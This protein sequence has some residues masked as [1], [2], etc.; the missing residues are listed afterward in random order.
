VTQNDDTPISISKAPT[1]STEQR[2]RHQQW[3][4][5][6][7][8]KHAD[9]TKRRSATLAARRTLPALES[10]AEL[11]EGVAYS[12]RAGI[13]EGYLE[14]NDEL[15]R[16]LNALLALLKAANLDA[17]IDDLMNDPA[18]EI[19]RDVQMTEQILAAASALQTYVD[20]KADPPDPTLAAEMALPRPE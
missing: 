8:V 9:E 3:A 7:E 17:G 16:L 19:V 10:A 11:G 4:E 15:T 13:D 18:E 12:A 6:V 14:V 5:K 1:I 20:E 2:V